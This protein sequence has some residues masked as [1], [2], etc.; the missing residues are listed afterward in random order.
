[1]SH[2]ESDIPSNIDYRRYPNVVRIKK[3]LFS[4]VRTIIRIKRIITKKVRTKLESTKIIF[5]DR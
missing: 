1:M 5:I 3:Y 4:R 2:L